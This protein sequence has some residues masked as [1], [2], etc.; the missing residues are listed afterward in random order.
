MNVIDAL[1]AKLRFLLAREDEKGEYSSG[2]IS[3]L[4]RDEF[5]RLCKGRTG[6]ILEIGCGEGLFMAKL[7]NDDS[8]RYLFGIDILKESL[9]MARAKAGINE[10]KKVN[11]IAADG[12]ALCF[13]DNIFDCVVCLNT[14]YNLPS[15]VEVKRIILEALRVAK[16]GAEV[17]VDIRNKGDLF[18]SFRYKFIKLYDSKC[19]VNV[20]QYEPEEIKGIFQENGAVILEARPVRV[21]LNLS[22]PVIIIRAK[23][24]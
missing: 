15:I 5:L 22:M 14:L 3:S 12:Q 9:D 18:T 21:F 7:S 6:K 11:L 4:V 20:K 2:Y 1:Y 23:K 19:A 24:I 17:I 10:L 16:R 8:Q 13:K